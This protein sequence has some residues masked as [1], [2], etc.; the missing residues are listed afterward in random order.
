VTRS[1]L[2]R[3]AGVALTA[4]VLSTLVGV[5]LPAMAASV[6]T[7]GTAAEPNATSTCHGNSGGHGQG[8]NCTTSSPTADPTQTPSSGSSSGAAGTGGGATSGTAGGAGA[9]A[10][11][12]TGTGTGGTQQLRDAAG[13]ALTGGQAGP[14]GSGGLSNADGSVG[15]AA[16][17]DG[18]GP[19]TPRPAAAATVPGTALPLWPILWTGTAVI[20]LLTGAALLFLRDRKVEPAT[21]IDA[22]DDGQDADQPVASPRGPIRMDWTE[23]ADRSDS[24]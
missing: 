12:G 13:G 22:A 4:V 18:A 15:S 17:S 21:A 16:A 8:N 20:V 23:T 5:A 11:P 9:G 6:A 14:S 2:R 19:P 7:S 10:S 1:P 24:H 3:G